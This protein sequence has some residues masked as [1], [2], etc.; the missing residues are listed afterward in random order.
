MVLLV[1]VVTAPYP[2]Q[3]GGGRVPVPGE[4]GERGAS[5]GFG[6][7][8]GGVDSGGSSP[9]L[10]EDAD[11]LGPPPLDLVSC[12]LAISRVREHVKPTVPNTHI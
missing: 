8:R 9:L 7:G 5:S 4:R 6:V 2:R 12:L 11:V 10:D 3:G 1:G